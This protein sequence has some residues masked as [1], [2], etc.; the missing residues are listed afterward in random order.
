MMKA[1]G[2]AAG[3]NPISALHISRHYPAAGANPDVEIVSSSRRSAITARSSQSSRSSLNSSMGKTTEMRSLSSLVR[4]SGC[5]SLFIVVFYT[6]EPGVSISID[7]GRLG[8]HFRFAAAAPRSTAGRPG[9]TPGIPCIDKTYFYYTNT[10]LEPSSAGSGLFSPNPLKRNAICSNG[11]S[12][13]RWGLPIVHAGSSPALPCIRG[14]SGIV[15]RYRRGSP[16]H[17]LDVS[18]GAG[19]TEGQNQSL[20]GDYNDHFYQQ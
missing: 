4:N 1:C 11:N 12:I 17:R 16:R 9:S 18:C 20:K 7:G 19:Y 15:H 10:P 13:F 8:L 2:I 14:R 3:A 6:L 5:R